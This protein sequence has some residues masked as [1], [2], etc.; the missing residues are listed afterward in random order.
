M[1][2]TPKPKPLGETDRAF[3]QIK[4]EGAAQVILDEIAAD[5][6]ATVQLWVDEGL[7]PSEVFAGVCTWAGARAFMAGW[8]T[9][10]MG[11]C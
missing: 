4:A 11:L 9:A 6:G 10:R 8:W 2:R 5:I 7:Q 1:P 3:D